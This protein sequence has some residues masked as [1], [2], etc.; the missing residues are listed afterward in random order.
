MKFKANNWLGTKT[1]NIQ[2]GID[3]LHDGE[4][5]HCCEDGKPLFFDTAESRDAKLKELRKAS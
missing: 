2:Y 5:H 3:A 4:W 1:M